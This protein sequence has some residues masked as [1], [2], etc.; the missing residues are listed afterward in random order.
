MYFFFFKLFPTKPF[1]SPFCSYNFYTDALS[2]YA[3][4]QL[5]IFYPIFWVQHFHHAVSPTPFD[6]LLPIFWLRLLSGCNFFFT[7]FFELQFFHP[8]LRQQLLSATYSFQ[9]FSLLR[10]LPLQFSGYNFFS[11]V[12]LKPKHFLPQFFGYNFFNNAL[13][14]PVFVNLSTPWVR[15][16]RNVRQAKT[17]HHPRVM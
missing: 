12:F 4:F 7:G 13:F 17:D 11:P 16:R 15:L 1:A 10:T 5:S 2:F 14:S 8:V 6:D 3:F 9:P